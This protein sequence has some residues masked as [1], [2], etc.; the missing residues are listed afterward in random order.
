MRTACFLLLL[1][2]LV[3][4]TAFGT[5]RVVPDL[6]PTIT[7]ALEAS[8]AN[9]TVMLLPGDYRENVTVSFPLSIISRSVFTRD[10]NDLQNT[11]WHCT[12]DTLIH[13]DSTSLKL[14]GIHFQSDTMTSANLLL[15]S[16][17]S[18]I[19]MIDCRIEGVFDSSRSYSSGTIRINGL[20]SE[21][22][23]EKCVFYRDTIG[24][25]PMI[26]CNGTL[27]ITYSSFFDRRNSMTN[28][29]RM[30]HG[31]DTTIIQNSLFRN[32]GGV[33]DLRNYYLIENTNFIGSG[34]LTVV[35]VMPNCT[36][37]EI[38]NCIFD[39]INVTNQDP[40]VFSNTINPPV[41]FRNC[42]F[43]NSIGNSMGYFYGTSRLQFFDCEFRNNSGS[44]VLF[45]VSNC[46]IFQS[47]F[48][49]NQSPLFSNRGFNTNIFVQNTDFID[50]AQFETVPD[51]ETRLDTANVPNCYWDDPTGPHH[52]MNLA[53]LG[54]NLPDFVNPFP[55]RTAPVFP[56]SSTQEYPSENTL[57]TSP[58]ITLAYPNPFNSSTTIRY[59]LPQAG[60]ATI[61]VYDVTGRVVTELRKGY[62]PGGDGSYHWRADAVASGTYFVR[63]KTSNGVSLQEIHLI[64]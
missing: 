53:G 49:G 61:A 38:S 54:M 36:R 51:G 52:V 39:S 56:E 15:T 6:Y 24:L 19:S 16:T 17:N 42:R 8:L 50:N 31:G 7:S 29:N 22:V 55:F 18:R 35:S 13:V 63:M 12:G 30:I 25:N 10:T 4:L 33:V 14:Y 5:I 26:Y 11:I 34:S 45:R 3:P 62:L 1:F 59:S 41:Q 48:R 58:R 27:R 60:D 64:K 40:I 43:S 2:L 57:P 23:F 21:G 37:S 46:Q 47:I 9:D 20:E 28:S 32:R 44:S